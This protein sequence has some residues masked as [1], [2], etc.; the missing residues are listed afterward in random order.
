MEFCEQCDNMFYTKITTETEED[1]EKQNLI[2]YCRCCGNTRNQVKK[3]ANSVFSLNFNTDTIKKKTIINEY[4]HL[5]PTLPRA[6]GIKCPNKNCPSKTSNI[7][8]L[9]YDNKNMKYIY[10]CVDCRTQ[11]I[12]PNIW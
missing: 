1:T 4:S 8:Y 9:N 7:V 3:I 5:D 10:M 11:N 12:E 2:Y 6:N